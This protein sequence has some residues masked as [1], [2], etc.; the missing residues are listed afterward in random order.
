MRGAMDAL[1]VAVILSNLGMLGT[2]R[3]RNGI[4]LVAVQGLGLSLL[5]FLARG[6]LALRTLFLAVG[7]AVLKG[8]VFP[9]LLL[10]SLRD[11]ET[12]REA[13][14]YLGPLASLLLGAGWLSVGLW[15]DARLPLPPGLSTGSTL[16]VPVAFATL[17]TGLL[18]IV[19]RRQAV[20]QVVGYLVME[21][22]IYFFGVALVR[23]GPFLVEMGILLDVFVAV[24]IMGIAIF[25][26]SQTFESIDT[27]H[28]TELRE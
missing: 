3:L 15:L 23:D 24:F 9:A 28:L 26:I 16:V 21:N 6:D 4:R 11:V 17:L 13:G 1:L 8:A 5:P 18:L 27:E 19:T 12:R 22:G 20:S 25:R 10:R 14:P 7:T 2:S